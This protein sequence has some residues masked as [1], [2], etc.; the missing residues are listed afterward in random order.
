MRTFE[1]ALNIDAPP[2]RVWD[3]MIDVERWHE[4][5]RSITSIRKMDAGTMKV[6][7]SARV[8]QPKLP[9]AVWKVS[10]IENGRGFIWES[11]SP[12]LRV[13]GR[14]WIESSGPGSHIELSVRFEGLFGGIVGAM[15]GKLNRQYLEWEA[16]GLK[17]RSESPVRAI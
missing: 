17:R 3:I 4:W 10:Q 11:R 13:I 9:P 1:I 15:L 5:T 12:G 14:H 7:S 16:Q 2:D 6:G 8:I